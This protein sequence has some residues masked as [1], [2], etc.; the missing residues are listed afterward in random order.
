MTDLASESAGGTVVCAT[1]FD[2]LH[3]PDLVIDG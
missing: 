2:A 1:S 3:P